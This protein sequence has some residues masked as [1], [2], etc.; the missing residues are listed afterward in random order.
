MCR[1]WLRGSSRTPDDNVAVL[2]FGA[3]F[4]GTLA[5]TSG[6]NS[7]ET[8]SGIRPA[9]L[10]S[11]GCRA[12][13]SVSR[14]LRVKSSGT[15]PLFDALILGADLISQHR[16]AGARPVMILFS[17]GNDTIRLHSARES[18]E[19]SVT[20]GPLLHTFDILMPTTPPAGTTF[21]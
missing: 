14:L 6:G 10:C 21:R 13:D 2:Y 9:I 5:G 4:G 19:S 20:G 1:N 17:D 15:T 11:S 18:L 8:S 3:E 12:S 7:G 16:H